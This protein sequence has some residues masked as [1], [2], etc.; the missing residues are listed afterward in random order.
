MILSTLMDCSLEKFYHVGK[1]WE[2]LSR[3]P[4][5][6]LSFQRRWRL[7]CPL[8]DPPPQRPVLW[9]LS[10][11]CSSSLL[12]DRGTTLPGF[13]HI[14]LFRVWGIFWPPLKTVLGLLVIFSWL[15]GGVVAELFLFHWVKLETTFCQ[16]R[17]QYRFYSCY[18]SNT[19]LF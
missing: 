11:K 10:Q 5:C 2:R 9:H 17:L 16:P 14:K 15:Q 3:R 18:M 6:C 13:L 12:P 4:W 8:G 1:M 7:F 19:F